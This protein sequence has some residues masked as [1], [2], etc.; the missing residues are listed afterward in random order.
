MAPTNAPDSDE[1][2]LSL[3]GA[4]VGESVVVH[5]GSG[6][7][8]VV[9]SCWNRI[10]NKPVALDYLEAIGVD[11]ATRVKLVVVSHWHDDHIEGISDILLDAD[12]A[13]FVC[14]AALN[15]RE[16]ATL[17]EAN[18]YIKLVSHRSG[19]SEFSDVLE[20][21]KA[22]KRSS[23][24]VGPDRLAS[25]GKLIYRDEESHSEIHSL[26]PSDDT[27][28]VANVQL[29][30]LLPKKELIKRIPSASPNDLSVVL[31]IKTRGLHLL[32]GGDLETGTSER[33]GWQAVVA[34]T[35]CPKVTGCSYKIAHHGSDDSDFDGIW[36]SLLCDDPFAMLTPYIR[37]KTPRPSRN[38]IR[39]IQTRTQRAYCTRLPH[40]I[41][42]PR[43]PK[44]EGT[45]RQVART[46]RAIPRE[47]GHIRLRVPILGRPDQATIEVFNGAR[48]I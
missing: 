37:G 28:T 24:P 7:W 29:A 41:R 46:R 9:D 23:T 12:R 3:F 20:I 38:D 34:S 14:S 26:S 10:R 27:I 22:R 48:E 30:E 15:C 47:P 8:I 33:R 17:L 45:I 6:N 16:F 39:R 31:L 21:L 32:L 18:D 13:Q 1:L 35:C 36:S 4:G 11:I 43:R 44:V 19:V 25:E 42:P 5:I 2:E 40:G